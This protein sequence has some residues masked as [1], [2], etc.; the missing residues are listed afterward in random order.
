[1]TVKK[2]RAKYDFGIRDIKIIRTRKS[3]YCIESTVA[4]ETW[5]YRGPAG[6]LAPGSC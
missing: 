4:G 3:A 5:S 2:L 6:P 1:M